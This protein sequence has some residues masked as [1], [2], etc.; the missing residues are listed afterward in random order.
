MDDLAK[1]LDSL[2]EST[3]RKWEAQIIFF[4]TNKEPNLL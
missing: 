2:I 4:A 3:F 1:K